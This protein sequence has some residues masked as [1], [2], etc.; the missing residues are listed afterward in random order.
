MPSNPSGTGRLELMATGEKVNI[1]GDDLNRIIDGLSQMA[2]GLRQITLTGDY[3][4]TSENYVENDYRFGMILF[5]GSLSG[6]ATVTVPGEAGFWWM[7]N[8]AGAEI[9]LSSGGADAIL[10]NGALAPVYCDGADMVA[11]DFVAL[12]RA[13][14]A[15]HAQTATTKATEAAQSAA[16][17]AQKVSLCAAEVTKAQD[18]V[19]LAQGHAQAAAQSA[20]N[21]ALFDPSSYVTRGKLYTMAGG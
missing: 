14:S 20:A 2:K 5:K 21:A 19:G 10:S 7:A 17:A 6:P 3:I 8:Q 1:W 4:L 18:Q 16:G 12:A 13:Q 15:G 11:V 9:T